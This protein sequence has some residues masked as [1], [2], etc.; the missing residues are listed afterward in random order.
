MRHLLLVLVFFP[1]SA[2]AQTAADSI[3]RRIDS[4]QRIIDSLEARRDTI[5]AA[6][7]RYEEAE[8][9]VFHPERWYVIANGSALLINRFVHIDVD[10]GGYRDQWL[11]R[12]KFDHYRS[13]LYMTMVANAMHV[14][15]R[16]AIPIT[17]ASAVGFE[18]TQGYVSWRDAAWSCAGAASAPAAKWLL[19]RLTRATG[20]VP[21]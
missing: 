11:S 4:T 19:R 6:R 9:K 5:R 1:L 10:H 18:Y 13:A 3:Q 8:R 17:C 12:D 2:N 20:A 21:E 7:A 14:R 15:W 16:Y